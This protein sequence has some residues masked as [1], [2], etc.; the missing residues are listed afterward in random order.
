MVVVVARI[1]EDDRTQLLVVPITHIEPAAGEGVPIPPRVKR[2]LGLDDE[3]SWIVTTEL[4]RFV[5]PGP[6]IRMAGK[7]DSPLFGAIPSQLFDQVRR[8]IGQQ[9]DSARVAITKRTD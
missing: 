9:V 8:Q 7:K 1:V 4:N 3:P 6:D 2:D 5:W